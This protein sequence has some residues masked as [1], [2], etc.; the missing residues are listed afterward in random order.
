MNGVPAASHVTKGD[1]LGIELA[2]HLLGALMVKIRKRKLVILSN[3][4]ASI[5]P[6]VL[7]PFV[8]PLSKSM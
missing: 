5:T 7:K 3:A 2:S 8:I 6:M 1:N 4:K